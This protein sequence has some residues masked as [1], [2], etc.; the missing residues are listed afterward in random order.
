ME[1]TWLGNH[2]T[3]RR[4]PQ[5][6]GSLPQGRVL[7]FTNRK[8]S[9][10]LM[11]QWE[12]RKLSALWSGSGVEL[13]RL[14]LDR[15]A[16]LSAER[17]PLRTPW[18]PVLWEITLPL[19]RA[20]LPPDLAP[21][22][23]VCLGYRL[24][25]LG[26]RIDAVVVTDRAVLALLVRPGVGRFAP[27]DRRSIEDAALDL[28]DFHAGSAGLPV[29]PVLVVPN[30]AKPS[31]VRTLPLP[32]VG[33]TI[34]ATRLL[35]PGLV[36]EAA[37]GFPPLTPPRD[38]AAWAGAAYRPVPGLIDAAC[39]LH[40]RHDVGELADAGAAVA[41]LAGTDAAVREAVAHARATGRRVALFV[42]GAPG[43][44]KTLC[45]LAAAFAPGGP[46]SA[47][48]T[49][50]PTLV[51]VLREAL[52]RDAA[53]RGGQLRAARQRVEG[54]IQALP[55]FRDHYVADVG[56]PAER[57][58]VVDEAQR[59]WS[60]AHAVAK[61][62]ASRVPLTDSEPGHLL[63][64]MARHEGW[65]VLVCL[66]GGGQ[67]IH[68]GEGGLA[69]WGDALA[70]RPGWEVRAPPEAWE[71][72]DPRQRLPPL[73]GCHPA[74]ELNLG[75]PVRSLRAPH[76]ATWVGAMLD[77][78]ADRARDVARRG[79]DVPFLVTRDLGA[80]RAWL[81]R[82]ARGTRRAGLLASSG[83]RRL[84]AEGFGAVLPHQDEAAVAQWFL[85]RWP[86]VRA[87]DALEVAAT[88]FG[89]QGL[90]LDFA[91]LC[92]DGDLVLQPGGAGPWRARAFRGTAWTLPRDA[93]TRSNRLNA[94]RVLL[95][96]ARVATG[97]WVPRGNP[98]DPTRD[99]AALDAVARFLVAS[100]A[101][102]MEDASFAPEEPSA[103]MPALL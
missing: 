33:A 14:T 47:Y 78:D 90:E 9:R 55:R 28:A 24:L 65:A 21:I 88:E 66:I 35:L 6:D 10:G 13:L 8:L 22:V 27:A 101:A 62:R 87:S 44:G 70:V 38:P 54:V 41:A 30:G 94:Y 36:R 39:L 64:I 58:V 29:L 57:L 97:I 7:A 77:G 102:V 40:A 2:L 72:A 69:A 76:A 49:G 83:A 89:V 46:P 82:A 99:P 15:L 3:K 12:G 80:L 16:A 73:P 19:L 86:D 43:A 74:P 31:R 59:C 67:E 20:A 25:R 79:G 48:L 53:R 34:D 42:T 32:G 92:W 45:G 100:G 61:T 26:R 1:R 60:R 11:G 84:R 5:P 103:P 96:R 56:A 52:A 63:D 93:E 75:A 68:A 98:A 17:G 50:N 85:E 23:H 4:T 81:R 95:T 71:A 37:L 51:H 18:D 91:G